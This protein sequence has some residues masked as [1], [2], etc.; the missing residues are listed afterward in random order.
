MTLRG[1]YHNQPWSSPSY[2]NN[3]TLNQAQSIPLNEGSNSTFQKFPAKTRVRIQL[4]KSFPPEIHC[5]LVCVGTEGVVAWHHPINENKRI[6]PSL[7]KIQIR[8]TSCAPPEA[9]MA[10]NT[11]WTFGQAPSTLDL[12]HLSSGNSDAS[13]FWRFKSRNRSFWICRHQLPLSTGL[14]HAGE[15]VVTAAACNAT[16][17]WYPTITTSM[18]NIIIM[19]E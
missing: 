8:E 10:M 13:Y 17:Q 2:R 16:Q 18:N 4:F 14:L 1:Y 11:V 9:A 7:Q 19:M 6:G 15:E 5:D 12:V 3:G